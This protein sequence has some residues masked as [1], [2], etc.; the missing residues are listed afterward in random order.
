MSVD[1]ATHAAADAASWPD[2]ACGPTTSAITEVIV[3]PSTGPLPVTMF[4]EA[5]MPAANLEQAR[6]NQVLLSTR[7]S[8]E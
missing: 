4:V 3:M 5:R 8:E 6:D 7:P 2:I 1:L